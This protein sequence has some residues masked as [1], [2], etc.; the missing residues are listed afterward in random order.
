[1]RKTAINIETKRWREI[2]CKLRSRGWVVT[3]KYYGFDAGIDEDFWILRKGFK[4]ILFA[5]NNWSEG[6]IKCEDKIFEFLESEFMI[7]FQYG[8]PTNLK[9]TVVLTYKLQSLPLFLVE[10]LNLLKT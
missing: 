1:M 10:K 3:S 6:E 7:K 5:W 8:V 2:I 4:K 9:P